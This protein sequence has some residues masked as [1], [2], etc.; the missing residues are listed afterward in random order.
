LAAELR[1]ESMG[2]KRW[3][4][5]GCS[6]GFGRA[7]AEA[8]LDRGDRVAVTARNV[9]AVADVVA[10]A[11]D[12]AIGLPLDV[13]IPAQVRAARD[14]ACQAFGGIDILVNNAGH[15]VQGT[16][17]D[18]PDAQVRALFEVNVF[19][20]IDMIRAFLPCLREQGH[21]HIINITS[22]GGRA[23]GPLIGLYSASKYAVEGLST[24]LAGEIAGYGIRITAVEPGA[25]ATDFGT[26]SLVKADPS[27]P[28]C[29]IS[30]QV[31]EW[32]EHAVYEDPRG[33]AAVI[34]AVAD[35]ADPPAQITLGRAAHAMVEAALE[36][37]Q[38]ELGRWASLSH[39]ASEPV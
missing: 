9:A 15:G 27:E 32:L 38:A 33:A 22:V 18:V 19:G 21:G 8:A 12:R 10:R 16:V 7:L 2:D 29:A 26:R 3:F 13:T 25:F 11:P 35:L 30:E 5:T 28:Y 23:S 37:Q 31:D 6:T 4:I 24:G 36:T 1:E 14:A 20:V 39:R 17:E 34:L